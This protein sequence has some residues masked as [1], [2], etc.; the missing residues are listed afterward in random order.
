MTETRCLL[1]QMAGLSSLRPEGEVIA[2]GRQYQPR[3]R[4]QAQ[5]PGEG[6]S[7]GHGNLRRLARQLVTEIRL[8]K[9]VPWGSV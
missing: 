5:A 8:L 2:Q 3:E 4:E 6:F 7:E 1:V 9:A